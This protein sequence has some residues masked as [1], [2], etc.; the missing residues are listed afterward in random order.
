MSIFRYH[1]LMVNLGQVQ[2]LGAVPGLCGGFTNINGGCGNF[3]NTCH[4]ITCFGGS[5]FCGIPSCNFT[6]PVGCGVSFFQAQ[7]SRGRVDG[8]SR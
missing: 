4:V 8:L 6:Q 3:P 2:N 5:R 7:G 1:N